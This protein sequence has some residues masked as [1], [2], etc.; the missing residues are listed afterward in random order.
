[1]IWQEL[2]KAKS[3]RYARLIQKVYQNRVMQVSKVTAK[4]QITLP[5]KVREELGIV[6]GAEVDIVK[7]GTKYVLVVDPIARIREKWRG[8]F[9]NKSTTMD[10]LEQ[11]RGPIN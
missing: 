11:V 9:K 7:K 2:D 3:K 4:Y 5:V 1:M 8:K 6:P 10:Y